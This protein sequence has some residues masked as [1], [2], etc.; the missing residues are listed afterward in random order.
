MAPMVLPAL[1]CITSGQISE[2]IKCSDSHDTT[3]TVTAHMYFVTSEQPAV[4][5]HSTTTWT[6]FSYF[7]APP[8]SAWTVFLP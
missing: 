1:H 3:D 7:L 5:G 4:R 2:K 6:E 8:P